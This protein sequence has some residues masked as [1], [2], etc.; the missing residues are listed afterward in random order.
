M[1]EYRI[2]SFHFFFLL[3]GPVPVHCYFLVFL[4]HLKLYIMKFFASILLLA[5]VSTVMANPL[6]RAPAGGRGASRVGGASRAG[7]SRAGGAAGKLAGSHRG[8]VGG[9]KEE[10]VVKK[11]E[12]PPFAPQ[13]NGG[14]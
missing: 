8:G 1:L 5:I 3:L 10:A 11:E 13:P 12:Q 14:Q 9:Q 4:F 7:A 6:P 2:S